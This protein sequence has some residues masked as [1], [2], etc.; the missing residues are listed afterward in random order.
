MVLLLPHSQVPAPQELEEQH[1]H[2]MVRMH[3]AMDVEEVEDMDLLMEDL[4]VEV[5][6]E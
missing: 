6:Q 3:L 4:V 2:L 1:H 5:M